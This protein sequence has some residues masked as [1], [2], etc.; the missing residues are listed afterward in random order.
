MEIKIGPKGT[1]KGKIRIINRSKFNQ[2]YETIERKGIGHPDTIA[3]ILA[4]KISQ[5]YSRYTLNKFNKILHHQIDKL[6]IIGGKT[7]CSWGEGKFVEPINIIVAGRITNK[8][9]DEDIP[10][11]KIIYGIIK[12]HFNKYFPLISINKD[13]KVINKLTQ[14]AGPG[15]IKESKG[16]IANMFSPKEQKSVRGYEKLVANDTSYCISYYPFS[17][18]EESVITIERYLNANLRDKKYKWLG[19]DIKIMANRY[20]NTIQM[21]ICI[22]QIAKY[23]FSLKEYKYNLKIIGKEIL[24]IIKEDFPKHKI[25]LFIN[26]KDDYEKMN[27]YLTVSGASLSGDIGVVGRGNRVNGLITSQ[28]PMSLEGASGKNPRYYSGFIYSEL[29]KRLSQKIYNKTKKPCQVEIISQNGGNLLTPWI[30]TVLIDY[31]DKD[32]IKKIITDEFKRIPKITS[33][34]VKGKIVTY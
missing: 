11:D 29:T 10:V 19:S 27:V 26:T 4:S 13:L 24:N 34:F 20:K 21:T 7:K 1:V 23:V 6:M 28:R 2:E 31:Q 14:F 22:P 12:D 16:A 18:L 30:T 5:K 3:D 17:K 15:T 8:Y 25:K 9:L 32:Q 33:D